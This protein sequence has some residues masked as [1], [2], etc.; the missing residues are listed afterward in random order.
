MQ[1]NS[2]IS[3]TGFLQLL[4]FDLRLVSR[5]LN[6]KEAWLR[7]LANSNVP[8]RKL[9]RTIPHGTRNR[10]LLEQCCSKAVPIPRAVWFARCVGAN[11]LRGLKRK[12]AS[13]ISS[14]AFGTTS[15]AT[16]TSEA[17]WIREWTEQ[18]TEY[19]EKLSRIIIYLVF[20]NMRKTLSIK[21]TTPLHPLLL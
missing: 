19:I 15:A 1:W 9:S 10:T 11:E 5:S 8:L 12:G 20:S 2:D 21:A 7:D 18:V 14:T 3:H 4:L 16:M 13:G 6:R 17:T